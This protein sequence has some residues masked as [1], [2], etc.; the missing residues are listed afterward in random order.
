MEKTV[1]SGKSRRPEKVPLFKPF[2]LK[3]SCKCILVYIPS[4][5]YNLLFLEIRLPDSP[6]EADPE[7]PL[8]RTDSAPT[9]IPLDDVTG[10]P[11]SVYDHR[12]LPWPE[13][14]TTPYVP[15]GHHAQQQ[16]VSQQPQQ[17]GPPYRSPA[18]PAPSIDPYYADRSPAMHGDQFG[19]GGHFDGPHHDGGMQ[20]HLHHGGRGG[21]PRG[22]DGGGTWMVSLNSKGNTQLLISTIFFPLKLG[23]RW[24]DLSRS[25]C[26]KIQWWTSTPRWTSSSPQGKFPSSPRPRTSPW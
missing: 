1:R 5:S 3:A 22:G 4:D 19:H 25:R 8:E 10:N 18:A 17:F 16:Q 15:P 21:P 2:S 24:I 6:I 9:V 23:W 20:Q 26:L 7:V 11:E 12:H 13:P 14:K